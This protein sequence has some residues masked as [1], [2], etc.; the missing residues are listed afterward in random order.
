MGIMVSLVFFAFG[1]ILTFAVRAEPS[2]I[3][4]DAVGVII[5]LVSI[6]GLVTSLYRDQW[7]RR[8]FEESIEQGTP[9]PLVPDDE[10]IIVEPTAP[11]TAPTREYHEVVQTEVTPKL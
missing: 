6:A 2:G 11:I 8:I 9:P 5:M 7:R 3:S 4:L 1:A 10:L